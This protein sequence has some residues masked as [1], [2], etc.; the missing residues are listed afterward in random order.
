[1]NSKKIWNLVKNPRMAVIRIY[2]KISFLLLSLYQR[3]KF[4][5][6]YRDIKKFNHPINALGLAAQYLPKDPVILEAGAYLGDESVTLAKFWP[7]AL[8]HSFE[9]IPQH[10]KTVVE[11]QIIIKI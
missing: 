11:K 7:A 3:A 1:M 6:F 2:Q 8:L 9:P 5:L 10:Y 4:F